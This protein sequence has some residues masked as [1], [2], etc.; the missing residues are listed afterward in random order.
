M[1]NAP[2]YECQLRT[3]GCHD[4]CEKYQYYKLKN[5]EMKKK[6]QETKAYYGTGWC[7]FHKR[8]K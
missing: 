1:N 4:K 2:C 6:Q 8:K 5:E 3:L 7:F